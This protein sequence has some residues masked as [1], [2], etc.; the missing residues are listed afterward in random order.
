M[1][2]YRVKCALINNPLQSTTFSH[3]LILS[4][5]AGGG[6]LESPENKAHNV[7]NILTKS[8]WKC[9]WENKE[10]EGSSCW[11]LKSA[12]WIDRGRDWARADTFTTEDKSRGCRTQRYNNGVALLNADFETDLCSPTYKC[13]YAKQWQ[14]ISKTATKFL[15]SWKGH[16]WASFALSKNDMPWILTYN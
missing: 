9:L 5:K 1:V 16:Q 11:S 15:I 12:L 14:I 10:I 3:Y 13:Q 4:Q 2:S 8:K 7:L 6:G